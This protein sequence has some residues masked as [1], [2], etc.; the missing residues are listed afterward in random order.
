MSYVKRILV[1]ASRVYCPP[2][3]DV[4]TSAC[5]R[6]LRNGMQP[7]RLGRPSHD[8]HV[9]YNAC[10]SLHVSSFH[11]QKTDLIAVSI[12]LFLCLRLAYASSGSRVDCPVKEMQWLDWVP[13]IYYFNQNRKIYKK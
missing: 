12:S 11:V 2:E 13:G 10:T 6:T 3:C 5:V 8:D 9:T 1:G 4:N 7:V